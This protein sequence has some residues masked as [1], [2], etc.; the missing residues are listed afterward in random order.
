MPASIP[1]RQVILLAALIVALGGILAYQFTR[2]TGAPVTPSSGARPHARTKAG[3]AAA[4]LDAVPDVKLDA[5]SAERVQPAGTG[6]NLF[7]EKPAPPPPPP[8]QARRAAAQPD[9]NAPP[10]PP[11]PP[12]P[13]ALKLIGLVQAAGGPVAVFSDGRDVFYGREGDVIEG[14]YKILKIGVESVEMSYVDGRGRQRLP[15][16]G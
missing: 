1:R 15:L 11:P 7:R 3:A 4:R 12:P 5:L 6:R 10:P 8:P 9:P 14:R 2:G 13:I 16:T